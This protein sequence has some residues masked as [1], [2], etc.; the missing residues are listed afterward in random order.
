VESAKRNRFAFSRNFSWGR[1][2]T[3]KNII[4]A[5]LRTLIRIWNLSSTK[6]SANNW[7]ATFSE[8]EGTRK[9][10]KEAGKCNCRHA[11]SGRPKLHSA[12]EQQS[13]VAPSSFSSQKTSDR[14]LCDV[15]RIAPTDFRDSVRKGSYGCV[16]LFSWMG[17]GC[18]LKGAE[19]VITVFFIYP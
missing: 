5:G 13:S 11:S 8:T 19:N 2:R 3:L 16:Q 6:Q 4:L 12:T 1:E 17:M 14:T 9:R 18:R 15:G 10:T 7:S